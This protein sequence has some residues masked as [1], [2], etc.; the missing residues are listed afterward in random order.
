[1]I[2][3]ETLKE[4]SAT[5]EGKIYLKEGIKLLKENIV[6]RQIPDYS[7]RDLAQLSL[8]A[9]IRQTGIPIAFTYTGL[10]VHELMKGALTKFDLHDCMPHPIHLNKKSIFC[11][12]FQTI[13]PSF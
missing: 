2:E 10:F 13:T 6:L 8:E 7:V 5:D 3:V 1:M 12:K 4:D 9:M 11:K